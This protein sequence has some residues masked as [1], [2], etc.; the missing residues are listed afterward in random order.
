MMCW[1]IVACLNTDCCFNE[2]AIYIYIYIYIDV[3]HDI[4]REV[5]CSS[6]INV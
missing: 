4:L 2:L 3:T 1:G 6:Y 5:F